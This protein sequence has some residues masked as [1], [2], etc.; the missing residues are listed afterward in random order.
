[1][2][3]CIVTLEMGSG[4]AEVDGVRIAVKSNEKIALRRH[5]GRFPTIVEK[6]NQ[7]ILEMLNTYYFHGLE[8]FI[9]H[10]CC[11]PPLRF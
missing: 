11:S 5:L 8:H 6:E 1:M 3:G 7:M 9:P 10:I 2:S 4:L